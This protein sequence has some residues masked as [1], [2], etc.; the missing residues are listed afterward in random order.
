MMKFIWNV[1]LPVVILSC[2][3]FAVN[4]KRTSGQSKSTEIYN[5]KQDDK[6]LKGAYKDYFP[7]GAAVR[8]ETDFKDSKTTT[9]IKEQFSSLTGK[10][11][12]QPAWI[13]PKEYEYRWAKADSL[14]DFAQKNNLLVRGHCLIW[15]L[16]M[17]AWFLKDGNKPASKEVVL[18]RMR[19]HIFTVMGRYKGK[20]YSWDVVNEAERPTDKLFAL[21]GEEYIEKAFEFAHEADPQAKLYYNDGVYNTKQREKFYELIKRLKVKGVPIDGMGIQYHL[22]IEGKSKE[23]IQ[24]DIDAFKS[25]GLDVQISELDVSTFNR[26]AT[27]KSVLHTNDKYS[28]DL[29]DRQARIYGDIFEI[30]RKNHDVVKGVTFWGIDDGIGKTFLEKKLNKRNYP[31][32][33]GAGLKPKEAFFTIINF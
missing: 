8:P 10:Q 19:K 18:E 30:L 26:N 16:K 6:T 32:I 24:Q 15:Y 7:I 21:L 28:K 17:P 23:D 5:L 2:V 9:F 11:A 14:V 3:F 31:Y 25:L 22:G 12:M 29:E 33:F 4:Y 27:I 20:V 13:H 1:I